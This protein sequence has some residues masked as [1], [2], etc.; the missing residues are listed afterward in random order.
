MADPTWTCI[1]CGATTSP[2][3]RLCPGCRAVKDAAKLAALSVTRPT[4]AP[5]QPLPAIVEPEPLSPLAYK[6][7]GPK[8]STS[9]QSR[10]RRAH[11]DRA[12]RDLAVLRTKPRKRIE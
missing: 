4:T 9:R 2:G 3:Q 7:R 12:A 11:S 10:Y 5:P 8:A 1:C 6:K